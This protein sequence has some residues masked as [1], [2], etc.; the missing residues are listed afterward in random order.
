[1]IPFRLKLFRLPNSLR[2]LRC[3]EIAGAKSHAGDD[4]DAVFGISLVEMP[5]L[6][7]D[8]I[9]RNALPRPR[10]SHDCPRL[11]IGS[12]TLRVNYDTR[13]TTRRGFVFPRHDFWL[14]YAPSRMHA[15]RFAGRAPATR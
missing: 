7:L 8:D 9:D 14:L 2:R 1:M 11:V 12:G 3:G 10:D 6:A 15:S 5:H 4:T 13:G